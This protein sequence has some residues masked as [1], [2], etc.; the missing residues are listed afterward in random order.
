MKYWRIKKYDIANGI[1]LRTSIW[2]CGCNFHC[3]DC[4]NEDLWSFEGG[5]EFNENTEKELTNLLSDTHCKGLSILGGEPLEQGEELL[6]LCKR[7]KECCP[8]KDIWLWTGYTLDVAMK[9]DVKRGIINLCDYVV[10]GRFVHELKDN[11]LLFRGSSN[12]NIYHNEGG[13]FKLIDNPETF[14]H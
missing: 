8:N 12:Q 2:F 14:F 4:F 1:G 5:N 9:D 10:D 13:S 3:K 6:N 11:K 7:I